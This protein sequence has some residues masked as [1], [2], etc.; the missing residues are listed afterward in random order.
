MKTV[1]VSNKII[2]DSETERNGFIWPSYLF[3][4]KTI[5]YRRKNWNIRCKMW[6]VSQKL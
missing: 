4:G 1:E 5:F 6:E 3:E 2:N